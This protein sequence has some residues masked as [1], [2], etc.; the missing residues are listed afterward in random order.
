MQ[1][2]RNVFLVGVLVAAGACER[3]VEFDIQPEAPRLAIYAM[4]QPDSLVSVW[5]SHSK[6]VEDSTRIRAVTGA[7]VTITTDGGAS[8]PLKIINARQGHYRADLRARAGETY[9][10]SVRAGGYPTAEATT[11]IPEPVVI[12]SVS[13]T[14]VPIGKATTCPEG[15]NC[16]DTVTRHAIG[17]TFADPAAEKNY[18]QVSSYLRYLGERYE[19]DS[20]EDAYEAFQDTLSTIVYNHSLDP[21]VDGL[22]FV[23]YGALYQG[24]RDY[25]FTDRLFDGTHY[26]FDYTTESDQPDVLGMVVT[27]TTYHEEAY[28]YE[29]SSER[30]EYFDELFYEPV[31]LRQNI[32]GGY[33]IFSSFSQDSV[34]IALDE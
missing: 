1:I 31:P 4:L 16:A 26:T 2:L 13:H 17:I 27:L 9:H 29:R 21:A 23:V 15:F 30:S 3:E 8:Y 19:Y 18:Y 33:G 5:V 22:D 25:R 12:Q 20:L 32:R 6:S 14:I 10:L 11:R 24:Y 28:E 7:E 34:V